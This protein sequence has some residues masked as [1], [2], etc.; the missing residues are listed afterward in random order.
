VARA[1]DARDQLFARW[2]D[3]DSGRLGIG[4]TSH[5]GIISNPSELHQ[6]SRAHTWEI[7]GHR[8]ARIRVPARRRRPMMI[9]NVIK[10][11]TVGSLAW[12]SFAAA[13]EKAEAYLSGGCRIETWATTNKCVS[14]TTKITVH[15]DQSGGSYY[16]FSAYNNPGFNPHGWANVTCYR[17]GEVDAHKRH[18]FN[19]NNHGVPYYCPP[20]H[21]EVSRTKC[22]RHPNCESDT[23]L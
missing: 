12:A 8:S 13:P 15:P 17:A 7:A 18:E 3:F 16:K 11:M 4:R 20:T 9:K 14:T 6:A 10:A 5:Q 1:L 2:F 23:D 21:P 22:G 19:A